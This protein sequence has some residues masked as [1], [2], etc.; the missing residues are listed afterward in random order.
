M[1]FVGADVFEFFTNSIRIIQ[2]LR[3]LLFLIVVI[4]I[5]S[6]NILNG[7]GTGSCIY[8]NIT[9][10]I[11][12]VCA[13]ETL[14]SYLSNIL[15]DRFYC[16]YWLYKEWIFS[17]FFF[18]AVCKWHPT[19]LICISKLFHPFLYTKLGS[20]LMWFTMFRFLVNDDDKHL[21]KTIHRIQTGV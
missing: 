1:I 12:Q 8:S 19:R 5:P 4:S 17:T 20:V 9:I 13:Q 2:F 21:V 15:C 11:D 14:H 18:H 7:M 3:C 10:G 6:A 16:S